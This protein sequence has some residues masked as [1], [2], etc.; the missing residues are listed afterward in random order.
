M[1]IHVK[2]ANDYMPY[3][4]ESLEGYNG[5]CICMETEMF[6]IHTSHVGEVELTN[7]WHKLYFDVLKTRIYGNDVDIVL[8]PELADLTDSLD[9][10]SLFD[11]ELREL[12][13]TFSIS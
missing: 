13:S 3:D 12:I 2:F 1:T 8:A 9:L 10:A 11:I 5:L 4:L 7:N 6:T